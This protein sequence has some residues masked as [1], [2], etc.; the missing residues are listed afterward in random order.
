MFDLLKNAEVLEIKSGQYKSGVRFA[1]VDDL[2]FA[3]SAFSTADQDAVFFGPDTYRFIRLLRASL[4]NGVPTGSLRLID[5]GSGS[6]AGGIVAGR[7]LGRYTELVLGDVNRKALAYGAV[8]AVVND[9]A[10]VEIVHSDML[11]G[12]EGPIG[13]VVANPPYLVDEGERLYRHGGGKLGLSIALRIVE[14]GLARLYPGGRLIVYTGTPIIHGAD[15][16]F[17]LLR[18][19]CNSMLAN[20]FMRKST[21][22]Y[23]ARSFA[24]LRTSRQIGSPPSASP[25]SSKDIS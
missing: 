7:L 9:V 10:T 5:I 3:H 1:T 18:P 8:N 13:V 11:A 2:I 4:P 19:L 20:S 24:C 17:E 23:S 15:P 6:G 16:F 21:P 22:T 12:I 25:S 14:Q